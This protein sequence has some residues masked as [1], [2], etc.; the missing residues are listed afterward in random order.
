MNVESHSGFSISNSIVVSSTTCK[1]LAG[2]L[3]L[4][5]ALVLIL[6]MIS[7]LQLASL[8]VLKPVTKLL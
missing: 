8:F 2:V 5:W 1:R 4:A 3:E 7:V 6:I